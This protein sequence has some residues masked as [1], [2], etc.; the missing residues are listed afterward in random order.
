MRSGMERA[1]ELF[2]YYCGNQYFMDLNGDGDEHRGYQISREKEEEWRREYL[3]QFFQQ[4]HYGKEAAG[5]YANAVNFLK[6]DRS[7]ED[8]ERYL[9]YPLRVD[10]LD[11]ATVL[12]MLRYSYKLAEK[13]T[14]KK[15]F[16]REEKKEYLTV[17]D[18]YVEEVQKRAE[19]GTITRAED[20]TCQE[21]FDPVY[22]A[23]YLE[24][25][26]KDWD[27]LI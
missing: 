9:Y 25:L 8:A 6:S 26:R 19:E 20:Y 21:F 12:F 5:S 7:D 14:K 22:V 23:A 11:D 10:G 13:W 3:S 27:R 1:K 4:K 18:E 17:L 2:L 16:S 15:K 24:D